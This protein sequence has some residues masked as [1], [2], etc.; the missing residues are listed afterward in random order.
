MNEFLPSPHQK[1]KITLYYNN[2]YKWKITRLC[3]YCIVTHWKKKSNLILFKSGVQ[4]KLCIGCF[5]SP[6]IKSK[7][8]L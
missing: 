5:S 8:I 1:K 6:P 4:I 2:K 7:C 3:D